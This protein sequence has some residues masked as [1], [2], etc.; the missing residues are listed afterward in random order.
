MLRWVLYGWY[1]RRTVTSDRGQFYCL[2]CWAE[3]TYA[4]VRFRQYFHIFFVPIVR[5]RDERREIQCCTCKSVFDYD[6][7]SRPSNRPIKSWKCPNCGQSSLETNICC[8]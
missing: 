2:N 7:M 3:S 1:S 4:D 8:P 5:I 6:V